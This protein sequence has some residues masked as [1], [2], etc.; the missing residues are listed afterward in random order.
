MKVP[1][2]G[3]RASIFA[4]LAALLALGCGD[5][6]GDVNR[7]QENLV[8]KAI[9]E[10]EWWTLQSVVEADGDATLVGSGAS[11][12]MFNGGS[13]F[14]DL[15]LD[16]GQSASIGRIRWVIDEDFLY[17]YRSY[18]LIDGG[19]D[20][21]RDEDFRG[22]P[23][24]AFAID[25]HVDIRREYNPVTGEIQNVI[26]EN[27]TDRRWYER[28]FMRVDWSMNVAQSFAYFTDWVD[29][30]ATWRRESTAF[31]SEPGSQ[32]NFP[33]EW[34]PQFVRVSEDPDYRFANEWP[35]DM[36]D[37][38]HYMSFTTMTMF[39]P[40][41]SCLFA[42]GGPCQT[43]S[44]PVRTAFL[45]VPPNHT[46]A[47]AQ[48]SHGQFDLFGTFRTYQ[49]TYVRGGQDAS[50]LGE[51]CDVDAHCGDLVAGAFCAGDGDCPGG[52][53]CACPPGQDCE[54]GQLRCFDMNR[55]RTCETTSHVCEGGLTGDYGETDLLTFYR[56]Q[57]N[58]FQ[59]SLTDTACTS[60][61]QCDGRYASTPGTEGSIC[62]RA[63]R[64]C[65][66]PVADRAIRQVVYHLNDGYPAYLVK[67]AFEVMG[68]WNEVFMR[69]WRATRGEE[70][71]NFG[72]VTIPA[73]TDDPTAYC[74][75]GSADDADGDG[76][77]PA[78][79]NPFVSPEEWQALGV[80]NPYRCHIRN[81]EFT[82][83]ARPQSYDEYTLPGAYRYE[84][85]GDECMFILKTNSCDWWR[86]DA[87]QACGSVQNDQGELV[88]YEQQGDIRYQYFNY[89][90]QI[91]TA[92]GGVSEL[93]VDPTNGELLTADANYASIVSEN[94]T[95][96]ATQ[97][98][99]VLRCI[100]DG[101]CGATDDPDVVDGWVAGDSMRDYFG[102]VAGRTELPV[103]VAPSGSDGFSNAVGGGRPALPIGNVRREIMLDR[104][105]DLMPK[106][107]DLHGEDARF[108]IFQDRMRNLADTSIEQQ[109]MESMGRQALNAH[110][111]NTN[112]TYQSA[113]LHA[114]D[115]AANLNDPAILARMSPFR[116]M[117]HVRQITQDQEFAVRAGMVGYDFT[118]LTDP[119]NFLRS[120]YWEFWAEAFR[121]RPLGEASI[122]I[123]QMNLRAVQHHEVGHS[124]GLRHNFG[125]SFDRN[126]YADGY[127]NLVVENGLEL[128]RYETFDANG[129]G[130]LS[131]Q[132]LNAYGERLREVRNERAARG[133][134]NY[135]T[136]SIMDYNGDQSDV[137][138]LGRY[139]VAAVM[140]NY[141]DL[142]ELYQGEP[143]VNPRLQRTLNPLLASHTTPRVWQHSYQ[144]GES[145]V[146]DTDCPGPTAADQPI[147]QRCVKHPRYSR[148]QSECGGD[149]NCVC[150]NYQ[151]DV[152][153]FY[154]GSPPYNNDAN[155][156]STIDFYPVRY[157][158]CGDERSLD[159]SWCST[160]DAGESFSEAVDHYRRQWYEG[161][162]NNYNRRFFRRGPRVGA[163]LGPV[164]DVA[165][166]YQH[167]FFRIFYEPGFQSNV[168]S[169]S[170]PMG[171]DDQLEA[172]IIG[173]NWMME[174]VNL[175][176]EG[177]YAQ[178]DDGTYR[179]IGDGVVPGADFTLGTGDGFGM[180]T[181]FQEGHQGFFRAERG[182]VFYDKF[183]ALLALAIRDW[184]LSFTIDE[185]FFLNYYDLFPTEITEFFGGIILDEPRWFAPRVVD[186]GGG[187]VDIVHM[188][189][190]RGLLFGNCNVGGSSVPCG[191][192]HDTEYPE[193]ALG[194]TTNVVLRS[195]ATILALAQFPVFY[196]ASFEQRLII[197]RLGEGIGHTL[198]DTQPDGSP[199][200]A[201]G[202]R[203][204]GSA[205]NIVGGG[206]AGCATPEDAT[207]V[208]Y[209]S[210][211]LHTPYVA[212]KVRPRF[213]YNLEEEQLGFQ[214]L[215]RLVD[216]Q[217]D[218][219]AATTDAERL[220]LRREIESQ[221]S[222][223]EYLIQLQ[224]EYG[225]ANTFGI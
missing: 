11:L 178:A 95:M 58:F 43:V 10:G 180:W 70:L 17:A 25:D 92:F 108:H 55:G 4:G 82:E 67:P 198:P 210:D 124:V 182:G 47:S 200:C 79:Y 88:R 217:D 214:I 14:T 219:A 53:V 150:S 151:K 126:N 127:F 56:P 12:Y 131:N 224:G 75:A 225:I 118:E 39:S 175:P 24:A 208:I 119:R 71:P 216:L 181:E 153:D 223:L 26:S 183:Y 64:R 156:D 220:T 218:L 109:L 134:H 99:Q 164:I 19:N 205:H 207:Y 197:F 176:D 189:W 81:A 69:G 204:P 129:D 40:G 174:L 221:E 141:F 21:G 121:D 107:E 18:E 146:V 13:A 73:Q 143:R 96:V 142:V 62:D 15:A 103:G 37:T 192:N 212:V 5:P 190:D 28:Q 206:D 203:I 63:A 170:G 123:Q 201:Y 148:L 29:L 30:E 100:G 139:D 80:S 32:P 169:Q 104:L 34:A 166:I 211:R 136:G 33:A 138:G 112:Q 122:R 173:M 209:S 111:G 22:Q 31:I 149:R 101:G 159:L 9:F 78:E 91:G 49:R 35:A 196:D 60:D 72:A 116:G 59:R 90:D 125:A 45:R 199:A 84:F 106:A 74:F 68:N 76:T 133:A 160:G 152:E 97:W 2:M 7:V 157:L 171:L 1:T 113:A 3:I 98:F 41:G 177:S 165:K 120:R 36:V 147:F 184:G 6:I 163:S 93:R 154:F 215:R 89:I 114:N 57:H 83:P 54:A 145:C 46:F 194:D 50:T 87:N 162:A 179:R 186:A 193:P 52:A 51:Y 188:N 158:F 77:C 161:Y 44:V 61:W 137:S 185:R 85:V 132:E 105:A 155:G 222:F 86:T 128:P 168:G 65:T 130:Y 213:S 135:M 38:V 20:D 172:S 16:S 110:F 167:L 23:L 48:Q 66:I 140:W 191:G 117:E 42:G 27:T 8:D 115:T 195:W 94:L 102:R 144:G 202:D 187:N